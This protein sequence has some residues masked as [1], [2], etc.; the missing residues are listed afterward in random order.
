MTEPHSPIR[1]FRF[2]KKSKLR[3]SPIEFSCIDNDTTNAS[4]VSADP[5]G[6]GMNHHISAM[7]DGFEDAWGCKCGIHDQ[8]DMRFLCYTCD[9]VEVRHA[10]FGIADGLQENSPG[11]RVHSL[12]EFLRI[13]MIDKSCSDTQVREDIVEH[14]VRPAVKV[15]CGN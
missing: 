8:G 12:T 11:L 10:Q 5:L 14:G 15:A 1:G 4:A 13:S 2:G 3:I 9:F 7:L 6:E